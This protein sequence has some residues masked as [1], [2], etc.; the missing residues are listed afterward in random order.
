M[1]EIRKKKGIAVVK[2]VRKDVIFKKKGI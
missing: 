2:V 1:R